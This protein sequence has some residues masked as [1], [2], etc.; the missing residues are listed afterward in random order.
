MQLTPISSRTMHQRSKIL[1]FKSLSCVVGFNMG[2]PKNPG[3]A[4]STGLAA[5]AHYK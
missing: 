4:A 5:E 3:F 1:T 2:R